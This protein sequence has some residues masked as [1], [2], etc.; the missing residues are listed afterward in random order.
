MPARDA[1]ANQLADYAAKNK[2]PS[3]LTTA[4]GAPI[5]DKV[6]VV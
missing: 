4:T 3:V 6:C 5:G 2:T 1:A